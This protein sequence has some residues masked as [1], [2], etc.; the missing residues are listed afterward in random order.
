MLHIYTIYILKAYHL[1]RKIWYQ[2]IRTRKFGT[3]FKRIL[4]LKTFPMVGSIPFM[5]VSKVASNQAS[6]P[7]PTD[8]NLARCSVKPPM[9]IYCYFL[10]LYPPLPHYLIC[11]TGYI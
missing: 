2:K 6:H 11:A 1:V 5:L 8:S 9:F 10:F 4:G 3:G 7:N